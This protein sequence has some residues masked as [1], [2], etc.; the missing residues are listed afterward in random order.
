[1][2]GKVA[3]EQWQTLFPDAKF[4]FIHIVP[5]AHFGFGF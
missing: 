2:Q 5:E 1:M 3:A 4:H